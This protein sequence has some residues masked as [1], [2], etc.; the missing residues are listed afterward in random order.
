MSTR[1]IIPVQLSLT[2]GDFY[3]LWAPTWQEHGSEWQAFLGDGTHV[4]LFRS[5]AELLAF[6][7]SGAKHDLKEHPRWEDFAARPS[8]RVIPAEEDEYDVIGAPALLAERASYV[9]VSRLA[10]VLEVTSSLATVAGA[11]DAVIFFASHSVL[12]NVERGSDH[13]AG[14]QGAGEWSGVGRVVLGNWPKVLSSLDEAVRIVATADFGVE[15]AEVAAATERIEAAS[16]AA[17]AAAEE[18]R[19]EREAAR[20]AADPYDSSPWAAAGIDPIKISIQGRSMYTLRTYLGSRP[21]FLGRYGEIFTFPSAKQ[22]LRWMLD[23]DEHDLA[24]LST[25]SDL[26]TTATAGEL[27]VSVHR[28]NSYSFT[29]LTEDIEQGPDSV[30]IDQMNSAYELLADAADWAADD[31]LNSYLLANPRFQD[32]L[33]Y[34]LGST[35]SSGYVPSRPY[36]DKAESWKALED[37]LIKRFSKF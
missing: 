16:A 33:S 32:Y 8:D 9:N 24:E 1:A 19:R 27:I 7:D 35:E 11:E 2:E 31:S 20:Q 25:W 26:V 22:L 28:D 21:V 18:T 23:N 34:L 10:G 6:L 36:T 4:L 12:R 17:T 5:P 13:F 37:M 14:E 3:T 29:G 15:D 30:D